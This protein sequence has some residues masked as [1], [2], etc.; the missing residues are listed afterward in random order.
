V[1]K[2]NYSFEKRQRELAKKQKKADKLAEKSARKEQ[3]PDGSEPAD[4]Q[5]TDE[6]DAPASPPAASTPA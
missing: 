6:Q 5:A 4:T 3:T 2:P 1:P